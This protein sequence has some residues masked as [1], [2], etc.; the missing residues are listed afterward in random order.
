MGA[1]GH[2]H[3]RQCERGENGRV[4]T[5]S[6]GC[7][8]RRT[9]VAAARMNNTRGPVLGSGKWRGGSGPGVSRKRKRCRDDGVWYGPCLLSEAGQPGEGIGSI[10]NAERAGGWIANRV[11]HRHYYIRMAQGFLLVAVRT[12]SRTF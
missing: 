3:P 8:P 9:S 2:Q 4:F 7:K 5:I 11:E 6:P 10:S 12:F 1:C